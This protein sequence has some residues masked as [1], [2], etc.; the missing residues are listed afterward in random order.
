MMYALFGWRTQ[1]IRQLQEIPSRGVPTWLLL[2]T[3]ILLN[4]V[5]WGVLR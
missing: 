1:F 5:T 4:I 2:W 3:A